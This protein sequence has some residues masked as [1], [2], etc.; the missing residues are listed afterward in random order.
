M[1][2]DAFLDRIRNEDRPWDVIVIGGGATG[3][4]AAVDAAARGY[5]TVLLEQGDFAQGT[6]SRSTKLVHGGVRYLKQG[7][8]A[9]VLEALRERRRLRDNAPH[10]VRNLTFMLPAY[11]RWERP[12]YGLGLKAYDLLAGRRSF[13]KSRLLSRTRTLEQLPGV[14]AGDLRGS[15]AYHDGQFEDARMALALA[16]TAARLGAVVINYARVVGLLKAQAAVRGVVVRDCESDQEFHVFGRAVVN[17]TGVFVDSI[18]KYDEYGR[19]TI[20]RPSQGIHLVLD[21]SFFPSRNALL[22]PRT[23]DGRVLFAIPWH[24]RVLLGTTDTPV[25]APTLEPLPRADE[26]EY[27]I[28]HAAQYFERRIT[29]HDILSSFAGLRPLVGASD[30]SD[31]ASI[32]RDHI[33]RISKSGLVTVTGGKWTTYRKMAQDTID[34]AIQV[35]GLEA[36]PCTT[37]NLRLQGWQQRSENGDAL[38]VYGSDRGD[39]EAVMREVAGG[40]ERL[41]PDLP[42][43]RG[44]VHWAARHEMARTVGDVLVRR[45]PALFLNGRAALS[46]APAVAY[47]LAQELGRGAAWAA[48]QVDTMR[49]YVEASLPAPYGPLRLVSTAE[50]ASSGP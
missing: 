32:S 40:H 37:A 30:A 49:E 4:G 33:V 46:C 3:L 44:E 48:A 25:G 7:N 50:P 17:A 20:V 36:R 31:T 12:L 24:G 29:Q 45:T 13:G 5:R 19:P 14:K 16:R 15:I 35:G 43:Y 28:D 39:V 21:R 26:I 8:I 27:L 42:Y 9:L 22:I 34:I 38:H 2:R 47:I 41:H 6:S 1:N 10:L 18:R 11:A 23:R